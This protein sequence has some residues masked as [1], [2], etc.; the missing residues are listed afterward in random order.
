M[1]R[2]AWI[3]GL[4]ALLIAGCSVP[5][6]RCQPGTPE[7]RRENLA[8]FLSNRALI[9]YYRGS[10]REMSDSL[11]LA[12]ELGHGARPM[13]QFASDAR[14]NS[15]RF[16][17]YTDFPG[18]PEKR[19]QSGTV[20][21][22]AMYPFWGLPCDLAVASLQALS[23]V[24]GFTEP[25]AADPV[26]AGEVVM[27]DSGTGSEPVSRE[28]PAQKPTEPHRQPM[29]EDS[30]SKQ[31]RGKHSHGGRSHG[32]GDQ[33]AEVAL[34]LVLALLQRGEEP[35]GPDEPYYRDDPVEE[36]VLGLIS[37]PLFANARRIV[38]RDQRAD[39]VYEEVD[40]FLKSGIPLE[41]RNERL[42]RL[43][44]ALDQLPAGASR[45][46]AARALDAEMRSWEPPA[47]F[48]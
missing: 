23:A 46:E 37:L 36:W 26:V 48:P 13:A 8:R 20:F 42:A 22:A 38:V 15:A 19:I 1:K 14:D 6:L 40:D 35:S 34:C 39:A 5:P 17:P 28:R 25:D 3:A 44:R 7:S 21:R 11:E 47:R 24:T 18:Y 45:S 9:A 30:H 33:A 29:K 31:A 10:D 4:L 12:A 41:V 43:N 32:V 2:G 27:A 16:E